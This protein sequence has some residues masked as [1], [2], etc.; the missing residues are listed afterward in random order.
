MVATKLQQ[1]IAQV[2][3]Q[4]LK[5]IQ[6]LYGSLRFFILHSTVTILKQFKGN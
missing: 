2:D 1:I 3:Q 5:R 4:I 6:S